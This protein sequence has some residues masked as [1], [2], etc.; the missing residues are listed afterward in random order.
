MSN[1]PQPDRGARSALRKLDGDAYELRSALS[2]QISRVEA[3]TVELQTAQHLL[4]E[5]RSS[6]R[7]KDAKIATLE[8]QLATE[9][10]RVERHWREKCEQLLAHEELLEEKEAEIALLKTRILSLTNGT[11]EALTYVIPTTVDSVQ[12]E[13]TLQAPQEVG[14]SI[15]IARRGKAP[16]IDTFTGE[17]C[18]VL[19]EDWLPTFEQAAH[20]NS[21][22]EDEKL[23]QVAGYLRRKALQE[24]NLLSGTQKSS[25]TVATEEMRN[26]LDPGSKALAA[27]DFRHTVQSHKESVSDFIRGL[28]QVFRRAYGKEQI[29]TETRDTLLHG[30]LQ[31]GLSDVLIRAPAVSGALT[32][33][34]LCVAAKNEERRQKD[35]CRRHQYRKDENATPPSGSNAHRSVRGRSQADQRSRLTSGDPPSKK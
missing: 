15:T 27:Q 13:L 12:Q 23:L 18:D 6:G 34:E 11:D 5:E 14:S 25:F 9:K 20:W 29:S 17:N 30:Q 8:N 33:Q 16:P 4:E 24:W 1:K 32:Y 31:E 2:E 26:R 28:E 21:W 19:W 10:Q 35:L 3:L 22:S 7:E